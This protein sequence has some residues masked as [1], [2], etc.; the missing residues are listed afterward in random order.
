MANVPVS[1][2]E[3]YNDKCYRCS[4]RDERKKCTE[5]L[6]PHLI[7]RAGHLAQCAALVQM[8]TISQMAG[9]VHWDVHKNIS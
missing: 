7:A 3:I 6:A 9:L 8:R 5:I 1:F 4:N 2:R